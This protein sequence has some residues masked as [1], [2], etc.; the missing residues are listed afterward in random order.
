MVPTNRCSTSERWGLFRPSSVR[1]SLIHLGRL[2]HFPRFSPQ[3][4][5]MTT[6]PHT[7]L[8]YSS[9]VQRRDKED[10]WRHVLVLYLK[11]P[12]RQLKTSL[13]LA[14]ASDTALRPAANIQRLPCDR[15]WGMVRRLVFLSLVLGTFTLRAQTPA[16]QAANEGIWEGYDGEWR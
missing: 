13:S 16:M 10:C 3:S 2:P 5:R 1:P 14:G 4:T 8:S 11:R 12:S 9:G 15:V 7:Q 6:R